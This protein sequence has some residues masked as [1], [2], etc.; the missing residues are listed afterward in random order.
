MLL[1]LDCR[2]WAVIGLHLLLASSDPSV[3]IV[4][5][6]T[7]PSHGPN[8][9][10]PSQQHSN[11]PYSDHI[12]TMRSRIFRRSE[13]LKTP[14]PTS[15]ASEEQPPSPPRQ[16]FRL[17][18]R[19]A[20]QLPTAPTQQFLASVAAADVPIPSIEEP[21]VVDEDMVDNVNQNMT[22]FSQ[23][24][25]MYLSQSCARAK[26]FSPPKT[27]APGA[28][29]LSMPPSRF[30]DWSIDSSLSDS[31][32]ESS[33]PSTARS[34]QTSSSLF[35]QLSF[36][37]DDLSLATS[38]VKEQT[39]QFDRFLSPQDADRTIRAPS[40]V[41]NMRKAPW[42]PAM[43]KHL[44]STYMMYLQ[45]PKVTPV[46]IGPSGVPPYGVV[47]RVSR[48][49][50]RSWKGSNPQARATERTGSSTPVA[51]AAVCTFVQWP[52]TN[53]ATRAHLIEMCKANAGGKARN[54][55]YFASS[56]TPFGKTITRSR[57]RRTTPARSS[58]IFSGGD[59]A[60]SLAVST[61]DS[62]QLGGPLAQLT[63]SEPQRT[64]AEMPFM[65][66]GDAGPA[67]AGLAAPPVFD[68]RARLG[69]PFVA[70]SYGPS[71]SSTLA[72][73]LSSP[74]DLPRQSHT[75]GPR[76]GLK[77]PAKL[78]R[79]R[80]NTQKRRSRPSNMELRRSKRPSLPSDMWSEP[81]AS[82][83]PAPTSDLNDPSA[84]Q[85]GDLLV[86]Q[87]GAQQALNSTSSIFGPEQNL[88][89]AADTRARLGSPFGGLPSSFSFPARSGAFNG[90]DSGD[91]RRPFASVHHQSL[92]QDSTTRPRT[93]KT[94][95]PVRL[96]YLDER[97]KQ[98][99]Q[100]GEERRRSES[101]F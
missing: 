85:G 101:P 99:R 45:D 13:G 15:Q 1:S 93:P 29:G 89:P 48:E 56:P 86:S 9:P 12:F 80:S 74:T 87:T 71:S 54:D 41:T 66:G 50:R 98:I 67:S 47:V 17:K 2:G 42:T 91:I 24:D 73:A 65:F 11:T 38:P 58:S 84:V 37:S 3:H 40:R 5:D 43:S 52:H 77:S 31:D 79:S 55:R 44:W 70:K 96:A 82:P 59:M 94:P 26:A 78:G 83:I 22:P 23:A 90:F 95:L 63:R 30:P 34:T 32:C 62:M 16:R 60:M 6:R 25:H 53:A 81:A 100:R 97:L 18:R 76:R 7:P 20:P 49:A 57:A 8:S 64:M 19:N 69:S 46:R 88:Q 39:N 21:Y 36:T 51:E 35:S 92:S 75:V 61:S 28:L 10:D 27:P 33:R 72:D 68:A 14:E 4:V